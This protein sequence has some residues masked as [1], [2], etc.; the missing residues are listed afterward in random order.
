MLAGD[1]ENTKH[2]NWLTLRRAVFVFFQMN[3]LSSFTKYNQNQPIDGMLAWWRSSEG[4][5]LTFT[6]LT[7][8]KYKSLPF[9][10]VTPFFFSEHNRYKYKIQIYRV[11]HNAQPSSSPTIQYPHVRNFPES[12][13]QQNQLS[14]QAARK[15]QSYESNFRNDDGE[16]QK[17]MPR[18]GLLG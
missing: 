18:T 11:Q 1:N 17:R 2:M 7:N 9:Q 5:R 10:F 3:C 13:M 8:T 14:P 15:L 6:V 12:F 16:R 4:I